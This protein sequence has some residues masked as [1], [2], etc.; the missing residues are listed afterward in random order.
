[1]KAT[2]AESI[3]IL[4]CALLCA[5]QQPNIA[6]KVPARAVIEGLVTKEPGS[7]P[8]KKALIELI[9]ENQ[10]EGGNYTALSGAD[11]AFHI[12]GVLP[13]RYRLFTERTGLLEFDKH[14]VRNEGRVLTVAAGQELKDL[15]IRLQAAAV[16]RGRVTDEDGEPMANAQVAVLRQTFGSGRSRWE[17]IGGELTND[18][19]E[20]RI[21]SLAAGSYQVLV[22][23]PPDFRSLIEASG[24]V[25][26]DRDVKLLDRS[27]DS[28]GQQSHSV[29][30][31]GGSSYQPTYYPGTAD[32]S[33]AAPIE[34][35]PGDDFPANFSL[36]PS[37]SINIRGTVVNLPPKTTA[38]IMLQSRE[39]SLVLNGAEMHPDGSF[40]IRDVA[41]G[42]YTI[43][44][45]VENAPV[46]MTARQ[47][48]QVASSNIDDL[49]LAPQ[50][51]VN[52]RGRFRMESK[53]KG[54]PGASEIFIELRSADGE[55]DLLSTFSREEGFPH[56]AHVEPDGHFEWTNVAVGK[57]YVQIAGDHSLFL[58]SVLAD[59]REVNDSG[60]TL[61]SGMMIDLI[62]SANGGAIDGAVT[63]EKGEPLANAIV[64]AVPEPRFRARVDR[65]F[66][67]VSDQSGRFVFQ[68]MKPGEYTLLAWESVEN[69]AYYNPEFLKRYEAQ[70]TSIRV[71]EGERKSVPLR[72][73]SDNEE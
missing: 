24:T 67:T 20:Y 45:T 36:T 7:E 18:L 5:A 15:R 50:P 13:G 3:I 14:Q 65:F 49:R 22:T 51:G 37:A 26:S 1:M 33:Q 23:P 9:S 46:P 72:A 41:P 60:I 38:S 12:D 62:A 27:S 2:F 52:V 44:A 53:G 71:D 19:G 47:A 11:G 42:S 56:L 35:H 54:S 48:L 70:G 6:V 55:D 59:G 40:V 28:P 63:G 16:V 64:V 31:K 73:I 10:N 25:I 69:E 43:V 4:F 30:D 32:R 58:K 29:D 66:R 68:G 17:Q 57:Y 8:V 34:L 39:F 21:A 61:G